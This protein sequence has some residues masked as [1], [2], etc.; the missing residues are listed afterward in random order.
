MLPLSSL[1]YQSRAVAPLSEP[2]LHRLIAAS[3]AR[4]R[5]E[6]VTGLLIYDQGRFMQWLEGP[7]QGV[8]RVWQSISQDR[9]HTDIAL[10]G[11]S[12]VPVRCFGGSAMAL[13]KRRADGEGQAQGAVKRLGEFGLPAELIETLYQSPETAPSVLAGLVQPTADPAVQPS[14]PAHAPLDAD[15]RSLRAVLEGV[16]VPELL[17]RH[18]GPL[19]TPLPNDARAGELARLLVAAEPEAAFALIDALRADGRSIA[20]LCAGLFEPAAR[21][22]GDLWLSDDCS[23]FEVTLGLGHLQLALR[24]I[25][26]ETSS[27]KVPALHLSV[28]HSVLV[29]PSP[30][31]PHLL[32]SAIASEMFWRAGWD[33]RCEFPD[34]DE[35]LGQL[36]HER[37]FDVL[38]LSL[39]A[40]FT[41]EHRLPAMA[42]SIRAAH[43][44][45]RNPALTVIVDGRVF[46]EQPLAFATVGADAGMASARD[47]EPTARRHAEPATPHDGPARTSPPAP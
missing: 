22:L 35:A 12:T 36:V 19:R 46:H 37:W 14:P 44:H 42:A 11:E 10:L 43:A 47:I 38:D 18:A 9:R 32:G 2:D 29:A 40:A 15:R 21:A 17:A 28:P 30:R 5:K 31:E 3:Q 34:S 13:G 20:Q 16:I 33:V 8:G 25:S 1:M 26:V 24:R 6:G 4:N 27:V 45:S 39:S 7:T 23:E 41:R